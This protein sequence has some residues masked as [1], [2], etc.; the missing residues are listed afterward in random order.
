MHGKAESVLERFVMHMWLVIMGLVIV[1]LGVLR[2]EDHHHQAGVGALALL[3]AYFG[4]M[5]VGNFVQRIRKGS[6]RDR[7]AKA[8]RRWLI[9][10]WILPAGAAILAYLAGQPG[11]IG[12]A[13]GSV[14]YFAMMVVEII[15][16]RKA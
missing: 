11:G 9:A 5:I 10:Y 6:L 8:S 1:F 14:V 13:V 16:A 12:V 3:S 7:S 4:A 2:K 15:T